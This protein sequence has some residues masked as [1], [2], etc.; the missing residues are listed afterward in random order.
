MSWFKSLKKFWSRFTRRN[1]FNGVVYCSSM[2]DMPNILDNSIYIIGSPQAKWVV[3]KCPCGCANRID[4]NLMQSRKPHW[5]LEVKNNLVSLWPSLWVPENQ[6]GS[7]FW[8]KRNM[9]DWVND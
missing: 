3:L 4:I 2:S 6:C 7:H 5:K 1:K 9:I 8:L